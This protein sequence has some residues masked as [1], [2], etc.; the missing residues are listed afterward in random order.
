M[1]TSFIVMMALILFTSS[2]ITTAHC[3]FRGALRHLLLDDAPHM[4]ELYLSS[5]ARN[6]SKGIC[7]ARAIPLTAL[8]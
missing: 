7:M 4:L 8:R 1:V 6:S 3:A 5:L 2:C